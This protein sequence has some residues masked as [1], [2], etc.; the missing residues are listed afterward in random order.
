MARKTLILNGSPLLT[1]EGG[2]LPFSVDVTSYLEEENTLVLAVT[3][4][5]DHDYPYGKQ[6]VKRGGM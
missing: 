6:R 1:H 5:L 4:T 3:D 2:Y